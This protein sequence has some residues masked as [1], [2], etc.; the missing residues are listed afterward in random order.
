M[1]IRIA[2]DKRSYFDDSFTMHLNNDNDNPT[3][4]SKQDEEV[5]TTDFYIYL[6][7]KRLDISTTSG[8]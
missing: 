1:C 8:A 6:A 4:Y 7:R 3:A 2:F 5:L